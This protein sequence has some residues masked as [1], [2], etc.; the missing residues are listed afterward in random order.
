MLPLRLLEA[1]VSAPGNCPGH[2]GLAGAIWGWCR[3]GAGRLL[4][5]DDPH[6]GRGLLM[7][8]VNAAG[9]DT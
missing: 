8:A 5:V 4:L 7:Q 1:T 3:V 6:R 9:C 2:A